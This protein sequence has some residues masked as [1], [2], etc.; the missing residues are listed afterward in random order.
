[1]PGSAIS[2]HSGDSRASLTSG[3][4]CSTRWPGE[5]TMSTT[6]AGFGAVTESVAVIAAS[7]VSARN[8]RI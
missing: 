8:R 6:V 4:D 3:A 1:M 5:I 2:T 7:S